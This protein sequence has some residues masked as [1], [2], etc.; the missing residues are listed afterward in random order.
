M[1]PPSNGYLGDKDQA[2]VYA[3]EIIKAGGLA[4][5]EPEYGGDMGRDNVYWG[6]RVKFFSKTMIENRQLVKENIGA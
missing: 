6:H 2:K 5:I 4:W 3:E 1:T